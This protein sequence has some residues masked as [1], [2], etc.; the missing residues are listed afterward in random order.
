[1]KI[2]RCQFYEKHRWFRLIRRSK[3]LKN[4]RIRYKWLKEKYENTPI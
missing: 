1:M 4:S 2:V 3:T